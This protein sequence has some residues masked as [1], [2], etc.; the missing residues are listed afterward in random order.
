M[1]MFAAA[2]FIVGAVVIARGPEAHRAVFGR[3][4]APS[5]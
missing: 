2:A 3:A 1:G 5:S 4:D